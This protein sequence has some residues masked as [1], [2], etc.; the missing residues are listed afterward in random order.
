MTIIVQEGIASITA[1]RVA[2]EANIAVGQIHHHF[3][4][5]GQLKA[6]A[7]IKVTDQLITQAEHTH[8]D[9]SI[10]DKIIKIVSPIIGKEGLMIRKLWNEATFLSERD[11]DIKQAYQQSTEEW[12]K[13]IVKL[14]D[15]AVAT[16]KISTN[17]VSELAWRLIALSCGIDNLVIVD[18]FHFSQ[19]AVNNHIIALLQ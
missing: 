17:N 11:P 3:K 2:K 9:E 7:L 5:I 16:N 15:E 14:L 12:H 1:R 19:E 8:P 13:A 10:L 6:Q 18:G 4:S